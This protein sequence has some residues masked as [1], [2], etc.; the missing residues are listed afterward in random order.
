MSRTMGNQHG[1][2]RRSLGKEKRG[3]IL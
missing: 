1:K 3:K 2:Y